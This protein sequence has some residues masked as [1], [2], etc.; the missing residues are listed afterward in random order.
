MKYKIIE[1]KQRSAQ[2]LS[3]FHKQNVEGFNRK[4]TFNLSVNYYEGIV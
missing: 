2:G 3:S 4:L 1:F